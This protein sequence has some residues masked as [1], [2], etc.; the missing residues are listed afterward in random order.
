MTMRRMNNIPLFSP[1]KR[2]KKALRT[3]LEL[4][5][6]EAHVRRSI[7]TTS[8]LYKRGEEQEHLA[9]G[10]KI[11]TKEM[12]SGG[13]KGIFWNCR[14]TRKKVCPLLLVS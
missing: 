5:V 2:K 6:G 14:G 11:Q 12:M 7:R 4:P 3:H 13:V 1:E 10:K 8:S 9:L